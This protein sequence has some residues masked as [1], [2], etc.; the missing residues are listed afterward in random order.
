MKKC[1]SAFVLLVTLLFQ[2]TLIFIPAIPVVSA[3]GNVTINDFTASVTKGT[4]PLDVRLN[5]NVTGEVTKWRWSFYNP[6]TGRS[7]YS[8]ADKTT[9]IT[10]GSTG[11]YGV[12]NATLE[13]WGPEG[14]DSLKKIDYII[15]NQNTSGLPVANF[16]AS[17]TSGDAPLEVT[18]TDSSTDAN[19]SLW[20]FGLTNTS[21]E[22]SP[23]FVFTSPGIYRVV[24][25]V[26]NANGWDAT[27]Q[28]IIVQGQGKVLPIPNFDANTSNGLTVQF[29]DTSQNGNGFYWDFGDGK[30]SVESNPTHNYSKTG[31]FIV[32][33]AAS[34]E[35]GTNAISKIITVKDPSSSSSD[36]DNSG[37][38][39]GGGDSIGS[40]SVEDS[41]SSGSSSGGSGGGSVGGSPEPQ[42]NVEAK[43]ISQ[44]FI[45]NGNSVD[46]AFPQNV[47]SV[48]N[49]SFD[50]KTTVGKTTTIVEMLK[51]QSTLVAEPP[52][53][54]I[55]KFINIWVGSGGVV[56]PD[57]IE[58]AVVNFKV[59]K[60]WIQD[61]NIDKYSI[62]LNRY[63]DNKWNALPTTLLGEDDKYLYFTA[64][65]PGF[66]PFAITG[67]VITSG[68][69]NEA[70]SQNRTPKIEQNM[71]NNTSNV[72]HTQK[73]GTSGNGGKVP[74]FEVFMG[75]ISLF[76]GVL[77]IR[78]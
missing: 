62:T 15:A 34:N 9:G 68:T 8:V 71:A 39:D 52:A 56:T 66:S 61:K 57:K 78:K 37:S 27:A 23:T 51:N 54:E 50:S 18:F 6:Q 1:I 10:F 72:E 74:G 31:N 75:I 40:A 22:K 28:D 25:E 76:A 7:S 17:T 29:T 13:V 55:Y 41:S 19:S 42:S 5:S 24:L 63:S 60:S 46:F 30:Y 48:V 43:E 21:A 77:Y 69:V 64:Q 36:S 59:E 73:T 4:V 3:A 67:K 33:L 32:S 26:S 58:N 53:D 38:G 44:N 12:F 70:Q 20:Y 2:A 49:I 11:A 35:N 45:G 14:N 65:T 47:T 16:S